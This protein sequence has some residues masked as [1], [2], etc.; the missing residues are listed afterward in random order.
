MATKF[1]HFQTLMKE[2]RLYEKYMPILMENGFDEW[3]SL[4]ELN[5]GILQK[6]LGPFN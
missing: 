3:D 6:D 4:Q 5:E 1:K 2:L